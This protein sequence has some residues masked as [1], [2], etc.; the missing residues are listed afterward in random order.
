MFMKWWQHPH[1]FAG[2]MS[3]EL[4]SPS[5]TERDIPYQHADFR[6]GARSPPGDDVPPA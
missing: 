4:G 5:A 1:V 6:T 3:R 2:V